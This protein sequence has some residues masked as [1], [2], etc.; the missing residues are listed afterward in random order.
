M[1]TV[2]DYEKDV[3]NGDIGRVKKI[4]PVD[5]ELTVQFEDRDVKYDFNELDELMLSYAATVHKSQG[6]EYPAV[7]MPIHTQHYALL[8]KNLLY[9]GITRARKLVVLVGTM[10]AVAIATKRMESKHRITLL[11]ERLGDILPAD[12]ATL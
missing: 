9:T 4:D 10:K 2:N 11:K 12:L 8:Q 3:F 5:Q 6:S 7:V 1:Q